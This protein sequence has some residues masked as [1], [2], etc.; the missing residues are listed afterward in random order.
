[1]ATKI[2]TCA[3]TCPSCGVMKDKQRFPV[4]DYTCFNCGVTTPL[5]EIVV[6]PPSSAPPPIPEGNPPPVPPE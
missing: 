3:I 1:M 5:E 2:V 6:T 4:K